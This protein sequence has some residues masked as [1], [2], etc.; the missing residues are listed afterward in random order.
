[1]AENEDNRL[2]RELET[3][4]TDEQPKTWQPEQL[5]PEPEKEPGYGY[6]W[7]RVATLGLADA[8]NISSKLREGWEPVKAEEQPHMHLLLEKEAKFEGCIEIGGLVLCKMPLEMIEQ[9]RK[10]FANKTHDQMEAVN[11]SLMRESDPRMPMF[12]ESKSTVSRSFGKGK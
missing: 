10:Y 9:R 4:E 1:M 6:K 12:R 2:A 3:R 7:I 11:N 8:R 5:L